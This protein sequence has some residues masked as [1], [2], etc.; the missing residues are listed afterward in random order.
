MRVERGASG[1]TPFPGWILLGMA[2]LAPV[3]VIA[4]RVKVGAPAPAF[5][6]PTLAGDTVRLDGLRGHPVILKFWASWCPT[7]RTELPE[8]VSTAA[9]HHDDGLIVLAIDSDE[10]PAKMQ[11]YLATDAA[12]PALVDRDRKVQRAYRIPVLPTT[13]FVDSAGVVRRVHA[14][15]MQ[16]SDLT[17]GL[18]AILTSPLPE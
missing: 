2:L 4:Q 14:G 5:A 18:R 3:S 7:C 17:D 8:L 10:S 16:L 1:G 11:K 6:L 12:L 9:A 13:V 15:A